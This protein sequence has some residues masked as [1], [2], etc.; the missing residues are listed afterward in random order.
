MKKLILGVLLVSTSVFANANISNAS[1]NGERV[2][3]G[4]TYAEVAS[5]LGQPATTY[6]YVKSERGQVVSVREVSYQS[7]SK[8]YTI[9]IEN[10]KVAK[11]VSGR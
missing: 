6:D 3:I 10:G 9:T 7:G 2:R 4:H 8:T 1:I 11:I 5:K